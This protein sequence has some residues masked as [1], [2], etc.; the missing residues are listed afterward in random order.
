M[1]TAVNEV[2]LASTGGSDDGFFLAAVLFAAP[3]VVL[4]FAHKTLYKRYRNQDARYRYEQTTQS[5]MSNLER[6]DVF[7]RERKR[8]RNR[9]IEGRNAEQPTQR[10]PYVDLKEMT[11]DPGSTGG[12]DGGEAG[13]QLDEQT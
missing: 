5:T 6:W 9:S 4:W 10:A 12:S 2:L 11:G 3:F 13:H 8:L 1:M 7:Q